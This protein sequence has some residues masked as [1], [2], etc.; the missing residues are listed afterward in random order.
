MQHNRSAVLRSLW[1]LRGANRRQ[2]QFSLFIAA[3]IVTGRWGLNFWVVIL[4]LFYAL[5]EGAFA[6][7]P[8]HSVTKKD[9]KEAGISGSVVEKLNGTVDVEIQFRKTSF[10]RRGTVRLVIEGPA[11][12]AS[13]T[14]TVDPSRPLVVEFSLLKERARNATLLFFESRKSEIDLEL[15]DAAIVIPLSG[16]VIFTSEN[17]LRKKANKVQNCKHGR[18]SW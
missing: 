9:V 1:V 16:K 3:K 12:M 11:E 18:C 8:M 7:V 4:S 10:L 6:S 5:N 2:A 17:P 15:Y 13:A 14:W